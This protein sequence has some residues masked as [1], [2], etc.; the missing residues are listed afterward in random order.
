MWPAYLSTFL[1]S[2][3]MAVI[4]SLK[5]TGGCPPEDP[6]CCSAYVIDKIYGKII[7]QD[8]GLPFFDQA[9]SIKRNQISKQRT[10]KSDISNRII[11]IKG[12]TISNPISSNVV[13]I[14]T[15][16]NH[17]SNKKRVVKTQIK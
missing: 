13:I 1:K 3:G 2:Y 10:S 8:N 14:K 15:N 16:T 5:I 6:L 12:R 7:F 9:V 4:D 11:D 17:G